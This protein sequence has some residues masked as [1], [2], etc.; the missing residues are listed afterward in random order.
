MTVKRKTERLEIDKDSI[1]YNA[2]HA[3]SGNEKI[4]NKK[5]WMNFCLRI[6][7][8]MLAQIDQVL[9]DRV[10]ISKTGWMLEA[11]QEKLKRAENE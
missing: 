9:E 2:A 11:I 8:E 3:L 1:I 4:K 6:K 10:G 5:E 7:L